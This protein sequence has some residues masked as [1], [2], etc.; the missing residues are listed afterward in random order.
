M[1]PS[2][3]SPSQALYWFN[4]SPLLLLRLFGPI[5]H[6]RASLFLIKLLWKHG[7]S[8]RGRSCGEAFV[9][10]SKILHCYSTLWLGGLRC[11][12]RR[13]TIWLLAVPAWWQKIKTFCRPLKCVDP[14]GKC[15]VCLITNPALGPH[16]AC[17]FVCWLGC[18]RETFWEKVWCVL[19]TSAD[20]ISSK[21]VFLGWL[22]VWLS[23]GIMTVNVFL[24]LRCVYSV[25]DW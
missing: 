13:Q 9:R 14:P 5:H 21:T 16:A 12:Y 17:Q 20:N 4:C 24:S 2:V 8:R 3:P 11:Q 1:P 6:S 15:L 7:K 18:C 25:N 22:L 10:Q 23:R 19:W